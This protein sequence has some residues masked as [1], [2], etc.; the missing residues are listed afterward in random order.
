MKIN[1]SYY[2]KMDQL[3]SSPIEIKFDIKESFEI[4]SDQ[5]NYEL[6]ISLNEKIIFFEVDEKDIFPKGDYNIYLNLEE[7]GK[8]NK[9]FLQFD[10][11]KEVFDSLKTLIKKKNLSIIKN[12]KIMKIKIINPSNEKEFFINAPLKEKDL[13]SEMKSLIPYIASLNERIQFLEKKVTKLEQKLDEIYIYKNDLEE[14][15][16]ETL[17]ENEK[18]RNNELYK[19]EILNKNEMELFLAWFEKKPTKIKLLL[20]SKRDGDLTS[21]FYDKCSGKYP[22]VILV[23]TSTGY[24]FGGYS[25]IPWKNS[26]YRFFPDKNNFIFSLDKKKKYNILNPEKAIQTC[27]S[28]FAFGG[29]SDFFVCN[30]CTSS[31]NNY[32]NNSG[33]YNTTEKYELNGGE[34]KYIVSSYEV[35]QIEY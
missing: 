9:Y 2:S 25:S 35:Y 1:V 8:I 7:L 28:F 24:R 16:K 34:N 6:K 21:T 17:K 31:S 13:K 14:L 11:L 33:T 30:N 12:E 19:S 29:G 5:K 23:K 20:D 27:P 10:S 26:S 22:T 4:N 15:K 32:N 18:E 3:S